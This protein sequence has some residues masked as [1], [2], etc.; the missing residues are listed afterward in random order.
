V[1]GFNRVR[2]DHALLGEA[3]LLKA[4]EVVA[5]NERQQDVSKIRQVKKIRKEFTLYKLANNES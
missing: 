3:D 2:V 1:A 4:G 5:E